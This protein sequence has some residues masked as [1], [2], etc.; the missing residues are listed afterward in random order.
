MENFNT[1]D[2]PYYLLSRITLV[3]TSALKRGFIKSGVHQVKPAY[4]G[5]LMSLWQ[6]DGP[7]IIELGRQAGL[8]PST[9]TGLLDR[10]A[11][12]GLVIRQTDPSDRRALRIYLTDQ[13]RRIQHPVTQ[14]VERVL[15]T[16]FGGIPGSEI[17]KTKKLLRQV[18]AKAQEEFRQ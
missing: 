10:M 14:T 6:N 18:L 2:C 3:I 17:K 4:L 8:E 12:D 13:G 15:S 11:H 7:R 5:V 1:T 9:M 16:V